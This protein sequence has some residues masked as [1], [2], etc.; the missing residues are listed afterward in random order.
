MKIGKPDI[1]TID[2]EIQQKFQDFVHPISV[3]QLMNFVEFLVAS[4]IDYKIV[5]NTSNVYFLDE[6]SYGV[7]I[8]TKLLTGIKIEDSLIYVEAGYQL[9]DFVRVCLLHSVIGFEGL[10]GIPATIGGALFMNAGAYGCTI[11]DELL[12]VQLMDAKGCVQEMS[13][14][15]CDYA[16]RSSLFKNATG[17]VILS[18]KFKCVIGDQVKSADKI[19]KYHIARHSYQEFA[20]PNLG[21]LFS[22]EGDFYRELTRTSRFF[23]WYCYLL[24]IFMKNPVAKFLL[25]KNPNNAIFNKLIIQ[26]FGI[27]K[28]HVSVSEK[29]LNI[30]INSGGYGYLDIHRH[31]DFLQSSL[32]K[33]TPLENEFVFEALLECEQNNRFIADLNVGDEE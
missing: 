30:L 20:Y 29:S 24:K 3:V 32:S 15:Y 26:Y 4:D 11:A 6:L 19:R 33:A 27:K 25:R 8:S 12:S 21:S 31:V 1:L 13:A 9:Q 18:A 5:G 28:F 14:S 7:I 2:A 22:V 10:E 16:H 17:S 23:S